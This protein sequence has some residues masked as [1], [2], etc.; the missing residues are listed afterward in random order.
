MAGCELCKLSLNANEGFIVNTSQVVS[1]PSFWEGRFTEAML[2]LKRKFRDD[3]PQMEADKKF[4]YYILKECHIETGRLVCSGCMGN[5]PSVDRDKAS[6]YAEDFWKTEDKENYRNKETGPAS[7]EEAVKIAGPIW[8]R[9]S[10][11]E[12]PEVKDNREPVKSQ[13]KGCFIATACY[14]DYNCREVIILRGFRDEYLEKNFF[15]SLL[16]KIYYAVSP[17][18]ANF[19]DD[20]PVLKD[21]TKKMLL[22]PIITMIIPVFRRDSQNH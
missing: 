6:E 16:V 12:P 22:N 18:L 3:I 1:A 8:K 17:T 2:G 11:K 19:V 7:V 9:M 4:K 15:G 20:K 13:K 5:F 14:G 10:G 21:F